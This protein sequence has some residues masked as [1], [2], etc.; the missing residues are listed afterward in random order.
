MKVIELPKIWT[1]LY[2]CLQTVCLAPA[3][4]GAGGQARP[5]V[6]EQDEDWVA[7]HQNTVT[8]VDPHAPLAGLP[9]GEG[10]QPPLTSASPRLVSSLY[11]A[12]FSDFG[13]LYSPLI[14]VSLVYHD[15]ALFV[16]CNTSF[17]DSFQTFRFLIRNPCSI[18]SYSDSKWQHFR[19]LHYFIKIN[20]YDEWIFLHC[21]ATCSSRLKTYFINPL[22]IFVV[23][24]TKFYL[25]L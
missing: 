9:P 17:L 8:H 15:P 21:V 22:D 7:P 4:P 11:F 25:H 20:C 5:G 6:Q 18:C 10:N 1:D 2:W 24:L 14:W 19:G 23:F 12:V 3:G 16:S 13:W